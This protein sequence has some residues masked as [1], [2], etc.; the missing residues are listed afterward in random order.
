MTKQVKHMERVE[1]G[2]PVN[3]MT[4]IG[5]ASI[6]KYETENYMRRFQSRR[7]QVF[8]QPECEEHELDYVLVGRRNGSTVVV[9]HIVLSEMRR[10]NW[11]NGKWLIRC[12]CGN[13][14]NRTLRHITR[15]TK[16]D[17]VDACTECKCKWAQEVKDRR[18]RGYAW[19]DNGGPTCKASRMRN[20]D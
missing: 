5:I 10:L 18:A 14:E 12:D 13:Y 8:R 4:A 9:G 16:K 15:P 19:P 1:V 17:Y 7:V 6:R 2:A 11:R 3:K 20:V